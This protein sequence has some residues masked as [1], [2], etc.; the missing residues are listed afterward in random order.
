[1]EHIPDILTPGG[2]RRHIEKN[3]RDRADTIEITDAQMEADLK[4]KKIAERYAES[5]Q[6]RKAFIEKAEK[7]SYGASVAIDEFGNVPPDVPKQTADRI[8]KIYSDTLPDM[9][10]QVVED[11]DTP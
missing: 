7:F 1:M 11:T 8:R 9:T 6:E 10:D 5:D 3:L 4:N 2:I